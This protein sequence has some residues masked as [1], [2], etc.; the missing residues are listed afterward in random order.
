MRGAELDT[1]MVRY[2]PDIIFIENATDYE[3]QSYIKNSFEKY[4]KLKTI[5]GELRKEEE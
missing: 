1:F 3:L 4:Q 5:M 2:K